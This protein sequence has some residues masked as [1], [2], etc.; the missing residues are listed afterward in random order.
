MPYLVYSGNDGSILVQT[1]GHG[2]YRITTDRQLISYGNRYNINTSFL[3]PDSTTTFWAAQQGLGLTK[4]K[5]KDQT[6][7]NILD[8]ITEKDGVAQNYFLNILADKDQYVWIASTKGI[9]IVKKN[10]S[11][12][13]LHEDV[14]ISESGTAIP[15]SFSILRQDDQG[16]VWMNVEDK[17]IRFKKD[18][19]AL[20]PTSTQTVI[21]SVLLLN[22]PTDWRA[23]K[24]SFDGYANVPVNPILRPRENTISI[25][26]NAINLTSSSTAEYSYR[27]LPNDTSWSSPIASNIVSFYRL[28]AGSYQFEVRSRIKGFE[29]SEP[30]GFSFRILK[31]FW[32]TWSFRILV[33]FL[34]AA[35]I[36]FVFRNRL[37]RIRERSEMRNQI[38]EMEMKALKAQMNPHF[39]HNA[40]NSIQSLIINDRSKEASYYISK[41]AKLLRQVL[42]NADKNL[43][44]LDKELYSLQ[45]YI[46][47]EQLRMDMTVSYT[48]HIEEEIIPSQ[49]KIPPLIL[50]PFVENALWHGLSTS[51]GP[52]KIDLTILQDDKWITCEITDNGIG[53][54]QAGQLKKMLPEGSLA[55]AVS[56]T[57]QRLIDFNNEPG[58]EPVIFIDHGDDIQP[59]GTTVRIF[60]KRI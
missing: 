55:K 6:N 57:T 60:I 46:D 42:E 35:L 43:I 32:E 12:G 31:P 33:V 11:S 29:W 8:Q 50:Q 18:E 5:L 27:L 19:Q 17:L 1:A 20:K 49:L 36:A 53:R 48:E 28:S 2:F 21:E 14:E 7:F 38:R 34:A 26:F 23:R 3:L 4:Y 56:I 52:K 44:T 24:D 25:I 47:L 41:F 54:K 10:K 39:I 22:Q 58:V 45:L 15:M 13:W 30:A 51:T 9:T 16:N 40:L 37:N 59:T